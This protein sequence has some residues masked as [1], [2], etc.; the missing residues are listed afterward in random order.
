MGLPEGRKSF[1][2]GLAVLIQYWR[3]VT[4]TQPASQPRCRSIYH[5]Y[6]VARVKKNSSTANQLRYVFVQ[7]QWCGCPIP[8]PN[9][10]HAVPARYHSP[11]RLNVERVLRR[12]LGTD[13][14]LTGCDRRALAVVLLV[15]G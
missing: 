11:L 7:M 3:R 6:Y 10:K 2:I 5:A 15:Y 14:R 12:L 4:D 1:K 13:V 8:P 9:K